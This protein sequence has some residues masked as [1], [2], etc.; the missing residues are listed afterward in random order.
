MHPLQRRMDI[1]WVHIQI[2]RIASKWVSSRD[3]IGAPRNGSSKPAQR[4]KR[5]SSTAD[6]C[7]WRR[8][9]INGL[10]LL[11]ECREAKLGCAAVATPQ[12]CCPNAARLIKDRI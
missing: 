2:G 5:K 10:C 3:D 1:G 6:R 11:K 8:R 9:R 4:P 12:T 7:L